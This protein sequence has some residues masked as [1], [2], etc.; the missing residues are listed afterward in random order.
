METSAGEQVGENRRTSKFAN[1]SYHPIKSVSSDRIIISK[2]RIVCLRNQKEGKLNVPVQFSKASWTGFP[3]NHR[4][5]CNPSTLCLRTSSHSQRFDI[6]SCR[7]VEKAKGGKETYSSSALP[8][9]IPCT[10]PKVTAA[11][12]LGES[13]ASSGTPPVLRRFLIARHVTEFYFVWKSRQVNA[14]GVGVMP[15]S[16]MYLR[17]VKRHGHVYRTVMTT[18]TEKGNIPPQKVPFQFPR[19]S[20]Q[21][22]RESRSGECPYSRPCF[23]ATVR[24]HAYSYDKQ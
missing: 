24:Q 12:L 9:P 10:R 1:D 19:P 23:R 13:S 7:I 2:A 6:I 14:N 22:D 18:G 5:S 8:G 15:E 17:M 11:A 3:S 20:I 4:E 16:V 21:F